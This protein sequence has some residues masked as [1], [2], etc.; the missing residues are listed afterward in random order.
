M[1]EQPLDLRRGEVRI[2]HQTGAR[3]HECLLL[4]FL[5]LGAALGRAP[6]LP[7]DG[8]VHRPARLALP[9]ADGL[10]LVRD[11]DG[12]GC[13][14]RLL[15]GLPR[16]LERD[17]QDLLGVVLDFAGRREMLGE[18]AIPTAQHAALVA[19]DERRGAGGALIQGEDCGHFADSE[20]G[21]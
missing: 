13:H 21:G 10:A 6:I 18:L 8:A 16:G 5:E 12:V 14:A 2:E 20:K 3:T 11:P 19:Q 15:D 1:L 7:H 9:G 17:A 4:L